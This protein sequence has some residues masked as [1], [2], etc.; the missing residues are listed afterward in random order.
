MNENDRKNADAFLPVL[1]ELLNS[2]NETIEFKISKNLLDGAWACLPQSK[3]NADVL[4]FPKSKATPHT[5]P[6]FSEDTYFAFAAS[7]KDTSNAVEL[8]SQSNEWT[9]SIKQSMGNQDHGHITATL[10]TDNLSAY[11]GRQLSVICDGEI[12]F[13]GKI[14]EGKA[15]GK[16]NLKKLD[17]TKVLSQEIV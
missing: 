7:P 16:A 17:L 1:H 2:D 5:V 8:R 11:E 10:V 3:S 4:E 12:I 6:V 9:L 13:S 14:I 15:K